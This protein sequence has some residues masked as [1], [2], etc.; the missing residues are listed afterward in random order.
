MVD[1]RDFGTIRRLPS[2]RYQASFIGPDLTRH[3]APVTFENKDLAVVWLYNE[4]K[5][6]D[7]ATVDDERWSSPGERA[8]EARLAAAPKELFGDYATRWIDERRNSKG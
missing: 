7:Q 5:R 1:R 4:K 2:G 3:N 6:I 8:E